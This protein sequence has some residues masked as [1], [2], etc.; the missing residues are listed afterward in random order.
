MTHSEAQVLKFAFI[1]VV[2]IGRGKEISRREQP[3]A[4]VLGI[5]IK[6]VVC[7][8]KTALPMHRAEKGCLCP[9][10]SAQLHGSAQQEGSY[11]N[12]IS[13]YKDIF[14]SIKNLI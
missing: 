8:K 6:A 14:F 11:I 9:G 5:M 10:A 1:L 12:L 3:T 7:K 2:K 4:K 13:Y